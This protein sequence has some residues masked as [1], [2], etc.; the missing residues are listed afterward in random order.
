MS[1][2]FVFLF[3]MSLIM[4]IIGLIKPSLVIRGEAKEKK[5]ERMY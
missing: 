3:C 2:L 5:I 1:N 4:L